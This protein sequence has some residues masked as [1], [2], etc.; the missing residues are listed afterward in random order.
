M[1]RVIMDDIDRGHFDRELGEMCRDPK[2]SEYTAMEIKA[3]LTDRVAD[4]LRTPPRCGLRWL[5]LAAVGV[6]VALLVVA[7][8]A[9][10]A[11]VPPKCPEPVVFEMEGV[12]FQRLKTPCSVGPDI[13]ITPKGD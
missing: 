1:N 10:C 6:L 9:G 5:Y 8:T 12:Q 4:N 13:L 7:V 2:Y 11:P 3:V